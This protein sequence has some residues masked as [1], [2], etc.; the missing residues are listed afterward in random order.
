MIQFGGMLPGNVSSS[1]CPIC[2]K[3]GPPQE[4]SS[5]GMVPATKGEMIVAYKFLEQEAVRCGDICQ[6]EVLSPE[7]LEKAD[8]DVM[9]S[10]YTALTKHIRVCKSPIG[11][12]TKGKSADTKEMLA[13]ALIM[14]KSVVDDSFQETAAQEGFLQTM[15][16][17]NTKATLKDQIHDHWQTQLM[18]AN[19]EQEFMRQ[20]RLYDPWMETETQPPQPV[21]L[22]NYPTGAQLQIMLMEVK[23]STPLAIED[24]QVRGGKVTAESVKAELEAKAKKTGYPTPTKTPEGPGKAS[25]APR[26]AKDNRATSSTATSSKEH[27]IPETVGS[28]TAKIEEKKEK[29]ANKNKRS[30]K[31]TKVESSS[32]E[33]DSN[34]S[35]FEMA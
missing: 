31:K 5:T 19:T 14:H 26:F 28:G 10:Q 32:G 16:M 33:T 27:Q 34:D 22:G 20:A 30:K 11:N 17:N 3:D 9:R 21:A 35:E 1:R 13:V 25:V 15:L 6:A 12:P 18:I 24:H 8:R 23:M 4:G 2:W 7:I 29:K